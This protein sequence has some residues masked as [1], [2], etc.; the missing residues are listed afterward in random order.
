MH[1]Q[2]TVIAAMLI[3]LLLCACAHR[4]V[5]TG[6]ASPKPVAAGTS[7][8]AEKEPSRLPAPDQP[9]ADFDAFDEFDQEFA[10]AAIQVTDPLQPLNR[11]IFVFNDRLYFWVLKPLARGYNFV[12]PEV[13]RRGIRNFFSNLLT[14]IRFSNCVLQGKGNAAAQEVARLITNTTLGVAGFWDPALELYGLE[15]S[16]ED[17]GQT[18]GAYGIGNGF[19]LVWPVLGP[20]SLRDTVGFFGD[21]YVNPINYIEPTSLSFG[22]GLYR[23]FND[24]SLRI[25]D[26]EAIKQA[27]VDP[28]IAVRDGYIQFRRSLIE[29]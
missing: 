29:Q 22:V 9:D 26:Y 28:Y 20:S 10:E 5:N 1:R 23:R 2:P 12:L 24:L 16:N 25:G 4:Q 18:L 3:M 19:Y 21:L 6:P 8:P 11:A 14:P 13:A 15:I 27:A 7:Q 17:L